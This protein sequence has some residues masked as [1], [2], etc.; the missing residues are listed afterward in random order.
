MLQAVQVSTT[1]LPNQPAVQARPTSLLLK[2]GSGSKRPSSR[3]RIQ[4]I[5]ITLASA[6]RCLVMVAPWLL[7]QVVRAARPQVL[8][9]IRKTIALQMPG[10][11][12][13][14]NPVFTIFHD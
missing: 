6:Y 7:L 4:G 9:G 5:V 13:S 3:H 12:T 2:A 1:P 11:F 14:I 10:R 8:T